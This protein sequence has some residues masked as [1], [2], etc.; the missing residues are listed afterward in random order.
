MAVYPECKITGMQA[1]FP[2]DSAV[3]DHI[4][5]KMKTVDAKGNGRSKFGIIAPQ[6]VPFPVPRTCFFYKKKVYKKMRLKW[7]K[8]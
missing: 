2:N 7:S 3:E 5:H 1:L 8:S 4:C 6:K